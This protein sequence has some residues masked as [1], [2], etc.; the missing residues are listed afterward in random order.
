MYE[1]NE[2]VQKMVDWIEEHI[3]E[4]PSLL[5]MSR[6]IGYSPS[7]CSSQ[8]HTIVGDDFA[9]VY[10][11]EKALS[12]DA[13]DTGHRRTYFGYR[14]KYGYSSSGGADPGLRRRIRLYSLCLPQIPPGLSSSRSSKICSSPP[15]TKEKE[16]LL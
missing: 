9:K 7:Y 4:E 15:T 8:F 3:E 11:R 10:C 1:W 13:G 2:T 12:R 5:E 14:G 16:R 6:Q